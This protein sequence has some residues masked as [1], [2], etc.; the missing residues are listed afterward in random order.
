MYQFDHQPQYPVDLIAQRDEKLK[1]SSSVIKSWNV[2]FVD[3]DTDGS[4]SYEPPVDEPGMTAAEPEAELTPE[5]EEAIR[6][7]NEIFARLEAE[8]AADE[9]VKQAEIEAAFAAQNEANYNAATNSYSGAYGT[10][11]ISED[12]AAQAASILA[13]KKDAF[14]DMLSELQNS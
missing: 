13:E 12:T 1:I 10:G 8:K 5:Q 11:P 14:T 9:A 7:A 3:A 6:N 4:D 2:R